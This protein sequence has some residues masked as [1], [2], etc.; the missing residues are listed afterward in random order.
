MAGLQGP[1]VPVLVVVGTPSTPS[2]TSPHA[3]CYNQS[4]LSCIHY[5]YGGAGGDSS[6][7]I[8]VGLGLGATPMLM[9]RLGLITA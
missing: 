1:S 3:E 8:H 9:T 5:M 2:G 4:K 6:N 7:T